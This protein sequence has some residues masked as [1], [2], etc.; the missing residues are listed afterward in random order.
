VTLDMMRARPSA[1]LGVV[2]QV[3]DSEIDPPPAGS[4]E[5][6]AL[7]AFVETLLTD[8]FLETWPELEMVREQCD[9]PAEPFRR[10]PLTAGPQPLPILEGI[11]PEHDFWQR[12][13]LATL[14]AV[15]GPD[16]PWSAEHIAQVARV[17]EG[18]AD[19]ALHAAMKLNVKGEIGLRRVAAERQLQA[20]REQAAP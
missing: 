13:Y 11:D 10:E 4:L 18:S 1:L 16:C 20:Q 6:R 8:T 9:V 17:A 7:A 19:F 3:L 15:M 14:A 12:A 5:H 2:H